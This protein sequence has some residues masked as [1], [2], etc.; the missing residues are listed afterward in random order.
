MAAAL[1]YDLLTTLTFTT[2]FTRLSTCQRTIKNQLS[3]HTTLTRAIPT[4]DVHVALA[5]SS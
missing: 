2:H 4:L 5:H 1:P 3:N